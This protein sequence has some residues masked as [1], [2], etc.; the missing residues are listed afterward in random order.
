[1]SFFQ[2]GLRGLKVRISPEVHHI[3]ENE[4]ITLRKN[5]VH[6]TAIRQSLQLCCAHLPIG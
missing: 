1:M 5:G 4:I 6:I 3:I 2:Q